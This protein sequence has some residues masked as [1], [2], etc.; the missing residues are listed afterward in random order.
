MRHITKTLLGIGLAGASLLAATSAYA[1]TDVK[2]QL[3]WYA[4]GANAGFAA[5]LQEGYYKDAGL[6]VT[7]IQGNGSANTAQL[8]ASGQADLAYADAVAVSQ[9]IAKGAPMKVVATVYQSNPNEVEALKSSGITSIADLKGKKIGVPAG[10]S[11]VTMLPL[12]L[13]ANNLKESD[14]NLLN[15]PTA[16]MVPALLQKQVDAI[17]GSVDDYHIQLDSQGADVTGFMF[18]DHGVPT[19]STSIF[20]SE[21]FIKDNPD[22]L[23]KFISASLKGWGFALKN[24][25]QAVADLKKTFPD[26]DTKLAAQQLAAIPPLFCSGGTKYIG[27]ATDAHWSQ[28]QDLLSKVGLLPEGKDPT[29]YYTNDYLPPESELEP[30]NQ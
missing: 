5:A 17:L 21:E 26:V 13:D 18:A 8:V 10:S 7:I 9:L 30:C 23:K 6:N 29:M 27:K 12:F 2:F 20:A 1:D 15:M 19:V 28:T 4:G 22:V 25:D 24:S 11:Q 3:N 16:S 14:V